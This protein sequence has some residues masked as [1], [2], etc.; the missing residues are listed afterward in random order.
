MLRLPPEILGHIFLLCP[1]ENTTLCPSGTPWTLSHVS[2]YWRE[3]AINTPE[4]WTS[5]RIDGYGITGLRPRT[6][7]NGASKPKPINSLTMLSSAL[8]WSA[9]LPLHV[10]IVSHVH[11]SIEFYQCLYDLLMPTCT[12]WKSLKLSCTLDEL[13]GSNFLGRYGAPTFPGLEE[14]NVMPYDVILFNAIQRHAPQ[15]N[16]VCLRGELSIFWEGCDPSLWKRLTCLEVTRY[17]QQSV[18]AVLQ[19]CNRLETLVVRDAGFSDRVGQRIAPIELRSLRRLQIPIM[20]GREDAGWALPSYLILPNLTYLAVRDIE[21]WGTLD[22]VMEMVQRSG[23]TLRTLELNINSPKDVSI[24]RLLRMTPQASRL[25]LR[26]PVLS[27]L[28][29]QMASNSGSPL[30]PNLEHLSVLFGGIPVLSRGCYSR[31][32]GAILKAAKSLPRLQTLHVECS[33]EASDVDWIP[34]LEGLHLSTYIV[35]IS[36]QSFIG[37]RS[38]ILRTLLHH[39]SLVSSDPQALYYDE[40]HENAPILDQMLQILE[41][42][43]DL[44]KEE[45]QLM[46]EISSKSFTEGSQF[47]AR[48]ERLLARWS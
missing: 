2:R 7:S 42:D 38:F 43:P 27:W 17:T 33:E 23:C 32:L 4:L 5:I 40:V 13:F 21:V 12:R 36:P 3:V 6:D 34:A 19:Q 25:I 15:L 22:T 39:L 46:M 26:G 11:G 29:D 1:H 45:L 47:K 16:A 44:T 20:G 14:L 28:F 10:W 18:L 8:E 24:G 41:N 30:V 48:A 37:S 35:K 9:G 31:P